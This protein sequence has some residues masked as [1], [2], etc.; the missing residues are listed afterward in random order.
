MGDRLADV[1]IAD[2]AWG[3]RGVAIPAQALHVYSGPAWPG[4]AQ[5]NAWALPWMI[6]YEGTE[7]RAYG[8]APAADQ[9]M[10]QLIGRLRNECPDYMTLGCGF[11]FCG[12]DR[13]STPEWAL[14]LVAEYGA[15]MVA[16]AL[17]NGW[18]PR[19]ALCYG[20]RA[21]SFAGCANIVQIPRGPWGVGT[22]G[23][24]EGGG[25]YM[26]PASSDAWV[27]QSGNTPGPVP[28][29]TD[30]NGC[31]VDLAALGYYGG[32]TGPATRKVNTMFIGHKAIPGQAVYASA[33]VDGGVVIRWYGGTETVPTAFG[34]FLK[35]A[36]DA[37]SGL[38]VPGM[39]LDA[40]EWSAI[41]KRT[42]ATQVVPSTGDG[43][44]LTPEQVDAIDNAVGALST[45]GTA[46]TT[47]AQALR[48]AFPPG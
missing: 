40:G 17:D 22:W 32:P 20:N 24:G 41:E 18:V 26:L 46:A 10:P 43:T 25:P 30:F 15:R 39:P 6:G 48:A 8:G 42:V 37:Q 9:D 19:A 36:L 7:E 23:F 4:M 11:W 1:V 47:A 38:G 33:L 28:G 13:S 21:V 35:S 16:I 12:A 3:A 44:G 29:D 45:V 14:P 5:L 31:Y 2:V 34:T 27:L